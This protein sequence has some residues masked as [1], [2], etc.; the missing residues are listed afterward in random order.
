M[1]SI[2][3]PE[4]LTDVEI[5]IVEAHLVATMLQWDL[6]FHMQNGGLVNAK[7]TEQ[8]ILNSAQ[9]YFGSTFAKN[10]WRQ[11]TG[12]WDG[13]PMMEV[14]G[15]IIEALDEDFLAKGLDASRVIRPPAVPAQGTSND[16]FWVRSEVL[17]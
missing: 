6:M 2:R 3:T 10:W 4:D 5:R 11:Q 15:P 16:P 17:E 14:A 13:T 8:H 12:G 1:K 9:Y 7:D